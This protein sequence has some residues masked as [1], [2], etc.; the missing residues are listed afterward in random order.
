MAVALCASFAECPPTRKEFQTALSWASL[1]YRLN[2][3]KDRNEHEVWGEIE[4][5]VI[6]SLLSYCLD[7]FQRNRGVR[8]GLHVLQMWGLTRIN[9]Y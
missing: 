1:H 7:R 3:W 8:P 6:K 4:S 9:M 2:P 5:G